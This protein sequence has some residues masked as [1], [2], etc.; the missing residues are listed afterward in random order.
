MWLG[1][2]ELEKQSYYNGAR[3]WR[4]MD[5]EG[6]YRTPKLEECQTKVLMI[7]RERGEGMGGVE[8]SRRYLLMLWNNGKNSQS[9]HPK[10][11]VLHTN[12]F[13]LPAMLASHNPV[14]ATAS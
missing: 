10:S 9:L 4:I 5:G 8:R 1:E 7:E 2:L 11:A 13:H 14:P 6:L 3:G 12:I